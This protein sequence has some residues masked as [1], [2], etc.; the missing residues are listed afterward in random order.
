MIKWT[1]GIWNE[2]NPLYISMDSKKRVY[3]TPNLGDA[4]IFDERKGKIPDH[5]VWL[6]VFIGD[7]L[8]EDENGQETD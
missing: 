6:P 2:D 7:D 4:L 3:M 8:T 5:S 1:I